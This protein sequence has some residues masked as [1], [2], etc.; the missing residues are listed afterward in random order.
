MTFNSSSSPSDDP[1]LPPAERPLDS[2]I[3]LL[4]DMRRRPLHPRLTIR[5]RPFQDRAITIYQ[6]FPPL[7][8][9]ERKAHA[10]VPRDVTVVR[11]YAGVV[12]LEL[13]DEVAVAWEEGG[14]APERVG[15]ICHDRAIPRLVR[16]GGEDGL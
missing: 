10:D 9:A 3:H 4:K 14:V 2:T 5:P 1:D 13:D 15:G 11:P 6:I 12:R 8:H 16:C 7:Q